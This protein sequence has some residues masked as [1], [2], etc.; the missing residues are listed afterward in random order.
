MA[1]GMEMMVASLLKAMG[2]N[3]EEVKQEVTARYR[4]YLCA[5]AQHDA[6]MAAIHA[7]Q[8]AI[9]EKLGVTYTPPVIMNGSQT[10][11]EENSQDVIR[12]IA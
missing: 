10:T 7:N 1:G 11:G 9:C 8:R 12:H 3:V 4:E 5:K 6:D 2:F